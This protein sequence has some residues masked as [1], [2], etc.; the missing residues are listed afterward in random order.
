[1]KRKTIRILSFL[2]ALF[3]I[4]IIVL[5]NSCRELKFYK[6]QVMY[7][8]SQAAEELEM[9]LNN[10][11]INL[12]K[13]VYVT[14][15]KQMNSIAT[16]IY[17]EAKIAKQAFSHLPAGEQTYENFNKFLSQVGNYTVYL[18]KKI[19]TGGEIESAEREKIE[20]LSKISGKLAQGIENIEI[21]SSG[22]EIRINELLSNDV[23]NM[24]LSEEFIEL[25]DGLTDYP[26]LI[27]D[28]PY[29]DFALNG[30]S[31]LLLNAEEI[32]EEEARL[33]GAE[34]LGVD[35]SLLV[36][37]S[38]CSG[39]I[40]S[41]DFVY[42]TGAVSVSTRGGYLV[43]FRKYTQTDEKKITTELAVS[44]AQKYIN[45]D[46]D[47][48]FIPTYNFTDNGVCVINF[49]AKNG[50]TICY[51]DLIKI[52]VDLSNG[53]IVFFESRGFLINYKKRN[54]K[55][56]KYDLESAKQVL[57]KS[58]SVKTH[59]LALI[60]TDWGDEVLCYEFVCKGKE[61]QDILVYINTETL[62]E[63]SVFLLLNT[64][65]GTLVK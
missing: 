49:A 28:G 45:K 31:E 39:K 41:Y 15:S 50:N 59:A 2:I 53:E 62:E 46:Y 14:T 40:S 11:N 64:N 61:N 58:L 22:A 43:Y 12:E 35:S 65:D 33:I 19:I 25:E 63:E 29:S 5:V 60:P 18:A 23:I 27:Y 34:A 3:L 10:I 8:R 38:I 20:T 47:K 32:S 21:D 7:T 57:S 24:D 37:E 51:T 36:L 1:M 4:S 26:T 54:I 52:G 56:P 13:A 44:K 16:E 30:N 48:N 55:T 9:C 17:A 6:T 42:G